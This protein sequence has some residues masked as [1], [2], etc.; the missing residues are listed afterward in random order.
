MT[1]LAY[2]AAAVLVMLALTVGTLVA[3][4]K[5][6]APIRGDVELQMLPAKVDVDHKS[7]MVKTTIKVKNISPTGSIAGLKVEQ[8]WWDKASS[9]TPVSAGNA[10]VKKPLQPGEEATLEIVL[11][12]DAK[13]YRDQYVFTHANGKVKVKQVKAF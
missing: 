5:Y 7:N 10:K 2:S 4:A 11:P 8:F 9:Q 6:V 12:Y 1:R 3:Q 13:M